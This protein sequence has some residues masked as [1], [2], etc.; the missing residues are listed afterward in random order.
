[1][2]AYIQKLKQKNHSSLKATTSTTDN[3]NEL[4]NLGENPEMIGKG[5]KGHY[6]S[7]QKSSNSDLE[8]LIRLVGEEKHTEAPLNQKGSAK[9]NTVCVLCFFLSILF[10]FLL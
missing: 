5:G 4:F 2:L 10:C 3:E 6:P 8:A 1:M 9:I 7:N